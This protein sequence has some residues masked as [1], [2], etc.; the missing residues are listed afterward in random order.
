MNPLQTGKKT[1]VLSF[2]DLRYAFAEY[3]FAFKIKIVML[4]GN[5][6]YWGKF[7]HL[8]PDF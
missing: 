1:F 4:T 2:K 6:N 5:T 7:D 3:E 8:F